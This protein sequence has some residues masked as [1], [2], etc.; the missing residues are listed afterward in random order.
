[1][2]LVHVRPRVE[3]NCAKSMRMFEVMLGFVSS[4]L[5]GKLSASRCL[6]RFDVGAVAARQ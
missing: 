2:I 5:K 4:A 3:T 1:M 6:R